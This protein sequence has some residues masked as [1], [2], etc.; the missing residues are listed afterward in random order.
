M[1]I[2]P[3]HSN[4]GRREKMKLN[5]CFH[6]YL[7]CLKGF[8]KALEAFI[9]PFEAPQQKFNLIFNLNTT[10]RNARDVKG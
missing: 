1:F 3:S 6:N 9:K 5:F 2:I 4:P 7:W 10:F 8:M